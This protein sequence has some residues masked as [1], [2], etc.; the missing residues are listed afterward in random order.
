MNKY[1][2]ISTVILNILLSIQYNHSKLLAN[3]LDFRVLLSL[4]SGQ[5]KEQAK[6]IFT[7]TAASGILTNDLVRILEEEQVTCSSCSDL[8]K[9]LAEIEALFGYNFIEL[10]M[11]RL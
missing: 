9:E 2:V 7:S 10:Q 6:Q 4:A 8:A 1:S 3:K 5:E 11:V